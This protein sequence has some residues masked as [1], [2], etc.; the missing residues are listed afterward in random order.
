MGLIDMKEL[1][2]GGAV[3]SEGFKIVELDF[4]M[5]VAM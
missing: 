5:L 1:S 2:V 3:S 4:K